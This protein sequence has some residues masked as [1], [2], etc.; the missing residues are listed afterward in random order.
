VPN[1]AYTGRE[2]TI[3]VGWSKRQS[4]RHTQREKRETER[5]STKELDDYTANYV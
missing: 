2:G 1:E 5:E 3:H 4:F